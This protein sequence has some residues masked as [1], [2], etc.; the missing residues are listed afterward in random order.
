MKPL[1][2]TATLIV[3]GLM[4][5][6]SSPAG[7]SLVIVGG[8]LS[9]ENALVFEAFLARRHPDGPV[10]VLPTAS[11]VPARSGPGTLETLRSYGAP[12][13]S[14]VLM[15][16][17]DRPRADDPDTERVL[18]DRLA[19]AGAIWFTGGN[20][21]R[22]MER[23]SDS[24]TATAFR[25]ALAEAF[26]NGAVIGGTSAGAAVM[27]DPMIAGGRSAD[28][29]AHGVRQ[30]DDDRGVRLTEGL[31][32]FNAGLVD[33]HFLARGRLGRLIIALEATGTPLGF[34]IEENSAIVTDD[35][36]RTVQ[37][38]GDPGVVFVDMRRA[39]RDGPTLT[40]IRLSLL[41]TGDRV[42]D[43]EVVPASDARRPEQGSDAPTHEAGDPWARDAI[44]G[45]FDALAQGRHV[46]ATT[47]DG[48]QTLRCTLDRETH[49]SE[50]GSNDTPTVI[51]AHAVLTV[52]PD[53]LDR[54]R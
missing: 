43:G 39:T 52:H 7:G 37:I 38:I 24:P 18:A 28:A 23:F 9:K 22:I 29:V 10:V 4:T 49:V 35:Q 36:G 14:D 6:C 13:D 31:G 27:S 12:D 30:H 34:G 5:G 40:G 19:S 44:T 33:Q 48:K 50:H 32:L 11:G 54:S 45:V 20:Q 46:V 2:A 26:R 25:A 8:G 1:L 41:C 17:V 3:T 53:G 42:I 51:N 15:V 21:S 47:D 16:T